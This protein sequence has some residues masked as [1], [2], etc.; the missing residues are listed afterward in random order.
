MTAPILSIV[1]IGRN[2][3]QRLV[4][5][6]Q[7]VVAIKKLDGQSE[8]IY[9]DS[10]SS[11]GSPQIAESLG[12][13]VIVLDTKRPT[14][15]LG[16]E[17]G[18]REAS[19]EF[20]LFLDGDTILNADFPGKA[21]NAI[22]ADPMIAAVWGHLREIRPEHSLYNRIL[23]LDW[24]FP[25]GEIDLCGGN[26]LMRRKALDMAGGYDASLIAG[27]E[28]ELCC[29]IRSYGYRIIHIDEPMVGHDLAMTR[30]GQYWKRSVRTGYAY[31]EVSRRYR[32]TDGGFWGKE[33]LNNLIRGASWTFS[34]LIAIALSIIYHS[35]VVFGI[36][37]CIFLSLAL[38]SAWNARWKSTDVAA[39]L[40]YGIHSHFQQIPICIGQIQFERGLRRGRRQLLIEYKNSA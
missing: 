2:E 22:T 11:D 12:A 5:C 39:L 16:R 9:V 19:S 7:S 13:K 15:A 25:T 18:W 3:G 33:R 21:L 35:I 20:I 8:L 34:P 37:C 36:W 24:I 6:L 32:E 26:V 29:R 30:F 4:R 17:A 10:G 1:V 40:L 28:P 14:A 27:E 38:R 23:D 31:A